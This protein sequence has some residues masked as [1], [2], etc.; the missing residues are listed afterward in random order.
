MSSSPS[1]QPGASVPKLAPTGTLQPFPYDSIPPGA[2]DRS[3]SGS[4]PGEVQD[5]D[6]KVPD[7]AAREAQ[8]RAQGRQEGQTEARKHFE[9]QLAQQRAGLAEAL[10]Q[11][12]R[13]RAAYFQKVEGEVVQLALSIARKILHREALLDPLLLAGIVR[14]ALE[15]I[16]GATGVALRIHPQN[17]AE[18]R[19]YLSTHL[20][21]ADLPEIVEDP[22]QPLDRC[23]LETSMGTAVV[24]LDV[25]LKEIEQGLMDLLAA[26]PG[27]GA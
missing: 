5:G 23:T 21:P 6:E 17:A 19:R 27:A 24:G 10:T 7:A 2:L 26:R 13:D 4:A 20:Q 14:V 15:K 25:Q 18:W 1:R 16:D 12:T 3:L 11:F 8:A 22:S 9:E